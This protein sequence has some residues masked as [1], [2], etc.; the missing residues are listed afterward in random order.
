MD[1]PTSLRP[2]A[3]DL[4]SFNN[5]DPT[6]ALDKLRSGLVGEA[7]PLRS[8]GVLLNEAAVQA[9][10]GRWAWAR[11]PGADRGGEGAGP[12]RPD[13]GADPDGAG[14][15]RP[16]VD[17]PGQRPAHHPGLLRRPAGR[18]WAGP[19]CRV[20]AQAVPFL[21]QQLPGPCSWRRD[22][23]QQLTPVIQAVCSRVT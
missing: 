7:E 9:K 22:A 21:A 18:S 11:G 15:L 14:G 10:A 6:E 8:V 13:P 5:I 3:A 17:V 12:L 1:S 19:S 20:V 2:L 4:A 16:H 23:V